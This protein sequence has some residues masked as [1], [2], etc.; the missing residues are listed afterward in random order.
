MLS[1]Q[2]GLADA[3]T[4]ARAICDTKD[5]EQLQHRFIT[6]LAKARPTHLRC[7]TAASPRNDFPGRSTDSVSFI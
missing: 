6:L 3:L 2:A 7:T 4:T 1:L 5:S